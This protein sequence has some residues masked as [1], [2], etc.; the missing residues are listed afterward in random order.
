[1]EEVEGRKADKAFNQVKALL[2]GGDF[3][4]HDDLVDRLLDSG[5]T[6]TDIASALFDML[7]NDEGREGEKI[8]EDS[9]AFDPN[10]Q[11]RSGGKR[12]YKG[13]GGGGGYK[14]KHG[15]AYAKRGNDSGSEGRWNEGGKHKRPFKTKSKKAGTKFKKPVAHEG[16]SQTKDKQPARRFKRPD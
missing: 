5:H 9:E 1:M 11:R 4:R 14:K 6:P 12:P 16:G 13:E 8:A 7:G 2:E 15:G 3:K 10:P